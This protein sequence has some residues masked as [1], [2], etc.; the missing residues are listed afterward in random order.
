MNNYET[1]NSLSNVAII[2][3]NDQPVR[4]WSAFRLSNEVGISSAPPRESLGSR[5]LET[6]RD[7]FIEQFDFE[8]NAALDLEDDDL[9]ND[10]LFE[11]QHDIIHNVVD[12]C[13]PIYTH[14][15]WETFTDLCAWSEDLSELGGPETDMNK[16]AMT[17]LYMIGC[18]LGDALWRSYKRELMTS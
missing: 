7:T 11:H 8:R 15:I 1:L 2:E 17:A 9:V 5:F 18:R 4:D 14:Q 10:L 13:V 6:I 16:N 3:V 12:G